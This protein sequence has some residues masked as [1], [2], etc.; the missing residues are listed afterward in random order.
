MGIYS[1]AAANGKRIQALCEAKNHALIPEDAPIERTAVG[2]INAAFGCAREP[3]MALLVPVGVFPFSWHKNSF[4]APNTH[5]PNQIFP[6]GDG[7][8][9]VIYCGYDFFPN[10]RK[11]RPESKPRGPRKKRKSE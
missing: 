11:Q 6:V 5:N 9:F 3:C 1:R 7:F 4:F 2:I 8:G 10:G